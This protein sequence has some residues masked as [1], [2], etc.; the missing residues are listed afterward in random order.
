M[1]TGPTEGKCANP[2]GGPGGMPLALRLSEVLGVA[3]EL[4]EWTLVPGVERLTDTPGRRIV[5]VVL[6]G[7]PAAGVQWALTVPAESVRSPELRAAVSSTG[8]FCLGISCLWLAVAA[9]WRRAT[10][11]L[12]IQ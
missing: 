1:T 8:L 12:G 3:G 10:S 2:D 9:M 6:T 11:R 4:S 7:R 5:A